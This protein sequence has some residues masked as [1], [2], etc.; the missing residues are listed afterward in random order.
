MALATQAVV[1]KITALAEQIGDPQG[2]EIVEVDLLGG[3]IHRVLRIFVDKPEGVTHE[4][5]ALLSRQLSE[6][7]DTGDVIPGGAY[8]LEVSSPGV[9]RKLSKP[10]DF[11]RFKGQKIKLSLKAPL[12][13]EKRYEGVFEEFEAGMLT[14]SVKQGKKEPK[15][16]RIE[17]EQVDKANLKF[18]W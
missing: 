9:D 10:K 3:G 15:L 8:T 11:E 18:E 5:C 16:V 7:L 2:L 14:L 1:E 4:D 6:L 12:D 13:G 17:L